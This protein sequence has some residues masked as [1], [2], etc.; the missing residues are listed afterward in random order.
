M[1]RSS[2]WSDSFI[3]TVD[4]TSR[5]RYLTVIW[6]YISPEARDILSSLWNGIFLRI[7][8]FTINIAYREYLMQPHSEMGQIFFGIRP[9][10]ILIILSEVAMHFDVKRLA[11]RGNT[12]SNIAYYDESFAIIISARQRALRIIVR[13]SII[14]LSHAWG[15]STSR[16]TSSY[17]TS[18]QADHQNADH[19][20]YI[21]IRPALTLCSNA[22]I[23][24]PD[25]WSLPV[26]SMSKQDM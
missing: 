4:A 25:V 17:S 23:A 14:R 10:F 9:A 5:K 26:R 6:R 22:G 8:C 11:D 7:D 2:S 18:P 13:M 3:S 21:S 1:K 19:A 12:A 15:L 16:R 20:Y 24:S